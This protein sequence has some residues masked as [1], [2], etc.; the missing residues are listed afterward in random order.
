MPLATALN[1]L[2]ARLEEVLQ[3]ERR[4]T[5]DA[6]HELRTPLAG[7]KSH[8]Q[9]AQAT[10]GADRDRALARAEQ[11]IDRMT[12]LV[13]QL[14]ELARLEASPRRPS[15]SCPARAV[16]EAVVQEYLPRPRPRPGR[17]TTRRGVAAAV[18]QG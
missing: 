1:E 15:E 6:A 13:A 5:G 11:G 3:R 12:R 7:I 10:A 16:A 17:G 9:I 4:F 14:L 18:G 2:L 8:L